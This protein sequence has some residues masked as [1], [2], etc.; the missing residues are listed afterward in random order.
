MTDNL[1]ILRHESA[2]LGAVMCDHTIMDKFAD[3]LSWNDFVGEDNR[4]VFYAMKSL[5]MANTEIDLLTLSDFFK[6]NVPEKD[7]VGS[8]FISGL[9]T[10][11]PSASNWAYYV[12]AIREEAKRRKLLEIKNISEEQTPEQILKQIDDI[13]YQVSV[14]MDR[15]YKSMGTVMVETLKHMEATVTHKTISGAVPSGLER[16]DALTCGFQ[17]TDLIIIAGRPGK[18]KTTLATNKIAPHAAKLGVPVGIFSLEMSRIQLVMRMLSCESGVDYNKLRAGTWSDSEGSRLGTARRAIENLPI[19]IDDEAGVKISSLKVKA[20]AMKMKENIGLLIIDYL[21]L[22]DTDDISGSRN[23]QISSVSRQL[24]AIAKSLNI[25][26]IVLS[27][28]SRAVEQRG[29]DKRP[30]LSDLRDSGAIEQDA[31]TVIFVH[32]DDDGKGDGSLYYKPIPAT[33][34]VAKQ[35]NGPIGDVKL[36]FI[37]NIMKFTE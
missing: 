35:R 12:G 34:I 16:L 32:N 20:K 18:G 36:D 23:D 9:A 27:Q 4:K 5:W 6:K 33:L 21:Q 25:P 30:Q 37:K 14:N 3:S 24:K 11:V 22:I 13:V 10:M 2:L 7:R 28:L 26:V 1:D 29:G 15:S 17:P 31:D 8:F 19:H